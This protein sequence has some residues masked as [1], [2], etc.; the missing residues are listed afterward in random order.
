MKLC[1]ISTPALVVFE[2]IFENNI[3]SMNSLLSG[4]KLKLRPHYKSN[5]CSAIAA[6]QIK[7]GAVGITCAKLSEAEDL[8]DSGIENI[9]I[10]NQITDPEKIMKAALLA[11]KCTLTVCVDEMENAGLLSEAAV[12]AGST[13]N[14]YAEYE[15]GMQRCGIADD[16]KFIA[17]AE[18]ID[19][20]PG[21]KFTGI[22][23]YAGHVSH[24]EKEKER[25]EYSEKSAIKL[26]KLTDKLSKKGFKDLQVSGG[27]T[28]TA[29]IKAE[30][31]VY[32]ELQAGSYIFLD[33]TYS[34]LENLPFKNS[35]FV[36][37]TVVS[38]NDG[39]IVLDA[40]VKSMG[41]DQ[42]LPEVLTLDG[43][44]IE[45]RIEANE[46]HIKLFDPSEKL[47]AGDRVLLIPGHCCS[48]VNLYDKMY[49]VKDGIVSGRL[50][51]TARGCSR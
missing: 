41:F 17:L 43:R 35:L 5:K 18:Y 16:E 1:Q 33:A 22:Q 23:A 31:N 32:T 19:K 39:R 46:E 36:I 10:A 26:R 30:G 50:S 37:S 2:D 34:K 11:K 48:T 42:G 24:M 12:S 3:K 13:V 27:S 51:I 20:L 38:V 14:C 4:R 8:C 47:Y 28:G 29:L 9:L 40:G 44:K 6:L 49:M 21:L 15:I 7:N 45:A 25:K